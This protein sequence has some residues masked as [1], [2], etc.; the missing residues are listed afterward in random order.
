MATAI[1]IAV[2]VLTVL[3]LTAR[4]VPRNAFVIDGD[5]IRVDG[6]SWRLSGFDAPETNQP[7][8]S[9]ATAKLRGIIAREPTWAILRHEDVY[10]RPLATIHTRS[11][12]LSWR[13]IAAGHAHGE[14]LIGGALTMF[15][16]TLRRGLW[17][18][19]RAITPRIWRETHPHRRIV[20]AKRTRR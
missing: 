9:E 7:G 5:T 15:A 17:A 3:R 13:M 19:D 18:S 11:G 14:G 4:R 16:H 8:G 20:R 12:P 10:G 2:V 6:V 1:L